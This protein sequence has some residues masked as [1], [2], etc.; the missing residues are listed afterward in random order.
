MRLRFIGSNSGG[1]GGC[2]AV[3]ETDR[4]TVVIQGWKIRPEDQAYGDV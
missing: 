4:D 1:G 2:P 3:Y